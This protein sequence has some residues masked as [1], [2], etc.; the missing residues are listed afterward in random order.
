MKV[1]TFNNIGEYL[2]KANKLL[3]CGR[4]AT[5][6]QVKAYLV[7]NGIGQDINKHAG[8]FG[9]SGIYMYTFTLN[10][11]VE[12]TVKWHRPHKRAAQMWP[13]SNSARYST[14]QLYFQLPKTGE[15]F[16]MYLDTR[17]N[18]LRSIK[19]QNWKTASETVKNWSHIPVVWKQL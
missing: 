8:S 3:C 18:Q 2:S 10:D 9:E 4:K 11:G 7:P 13:E 6:R 19:L 14:L 5:T 15:V 16:Q 12:V 17:S 1:N